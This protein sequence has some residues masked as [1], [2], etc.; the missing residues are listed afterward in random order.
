MA[1]SDMPERTLIR[2]A[3]VVS[4]DRGVDVLPG[5]DMLVE[6]GRI[7]AIANELPPEG[8]RVVEASG[9]IAIP[10]LVD[11]HRHTWQSLIRGV[12]ADWTLAEYWQ[13]VRAVFGPLYTPEDVYAANLL[14]AL[15]A[16]DAGVT[17]LVDFAHIM[18]SPEHADAAIQG[19]ADAGGRAVFCHGTPTDEDAPAWYVQSEMPHSEDIRRIRSRYFSSDDQLLTLA[20]AAR[21]PQNC[22]LDTT[23]RDW[24][25]ARELGIPITVHTGSGKW[26]LV[27]PIEQLESRGLLGADSVY[28]HCN[29]LSDDELALIARSGGAVSIA[30]E[31]EM[32]M[33]H[34]YPATGRLLRAGIRPSLGVDVVTGVGGDLFATM[35]VCLAAERAKV[36]EA[37]LEAGASVDHVE[38]KTEDVLSFATIE[39]ARAFGLDSK[40]GTLTPGKQADI[41][42]L[43]ADLPNL[44]PLNNPIAAVTLAATPANVDTVIVAG[45]ILKEGG[46]LRAVNAQAVRQVA[47]EARNRLFEKA[48]ISIGQ[49]W[50]PDV[51]DTWRP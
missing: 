32:H 36:N 30:P 41:V 12:A 47:E 19:L 26:G 1:K 22:T 37:A 49:P 17:T 31:V 44:Y 51:A 15:E 43:R 23:E 13:G 29:S 45:R 14:G 42:L 16:I 35:R 25:L 39:G 20:L 38:V 4:G 28:V 6:Q 9:M 46:E 5:A 11:T 7:A 2:G 3:M 8:C 21:G 50:F 48:G 24:R 40:I 18:N 33:G 27:R 34:G 10:G